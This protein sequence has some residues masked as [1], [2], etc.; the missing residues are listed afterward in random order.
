[1]PCGRAWTVPLLWRPLALYV[2]SGGPQN[3]ARR[4]HLMTPVVVFVTFRGGS[5]EIIEVFAWHIQCTTAGHASAA[6]HRS[7][8]RSEIWSASTR[9]HEV[10]ASASL[11][12]RSSQALRSR[13]RSRS[14]CSSSSTRTQRWGRARGDP[15]QEYRRQ[16]AH[17]TIIGEGA[18]RGSVD[19]GH[20][21]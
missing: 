21:V 14:T 10:K 20:R 2:R 18:F 3:D 13:G 17:P 6:R 15:Q 11:A 8:H 5:L 12:D 1:M 9:P 16:T 19:L 4:Q 7:H